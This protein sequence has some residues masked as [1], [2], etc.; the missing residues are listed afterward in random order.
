MLAFLLQLV[1]LSGP[2]GHQSV[3]K[4][5]PE[6]SPGSYRPPAPWLA[7]RLHGPPLGPG[8]TTALGVAN[9]RQG[10]H[11]LG[12]FL[13]KKLSELAGKLPTLTKAPFRAVLRGESKPVAFADTHR[14]GHLHWYP[15]M[16]GS[17]S[18]PSA[19]WLED[20]KFH[21]AKTRRI[22]QDIGPSAG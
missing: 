21:I 9:L 16:P 11:M 14:H 5:A 2:H 22:S 15:H 4:S 8:P 19:W 12:T 6:R 3:P 17:R 13:L 20:C 18:F 7:G 10:A 1:H